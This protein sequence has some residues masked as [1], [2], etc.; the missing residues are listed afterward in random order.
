[1]Q[2]VRK[3]TL[4]LLTLA[5]R[6]GEPAAVLCGAADDAVVGALGEYGASV[7]YVV[8]GTEEFL[9]VPA[10][11]AL[12]EIAGRVQPAAI[13]ITS[14]PTGKDV[15]ARAAVRL[16]SGIITDAVDVQAGDGGLTATQSVFAGTWHV[17]SQVVRGVPVV[18]V[19]PNA[20]SAEP[21]PVTPRVEQVEV[22][23]SDTARGAKI[24]SRS[25]KVSS[26]RP[27]LTDAGVVVSGGRGVG[28][29]EGFE[30][31]ERLADALGAAVGATRAVTDLH[32]V[33]HDLQVGQTGK[34]VAPS[35]Y[36][37]AGI[38]GAI[39]HRAG[40]QSSKTIVAVNKDPKAPIFGVS[41]FGVVGDLHKVVPA[42]IDEIAKRK[43]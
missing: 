18:T 23:F 43:H 1:P 5:R 32:W 24:T 34:T 13:L 14:G 33:A 28:T 9:S 38:S 36:V 10:A 25:P 37:A 22:G 8:P 19:R 11:E 39:Q 12:V 27:E 7:V 4:E 21:A 26:G 6:L 35:L 41:D 20:I 3:A 16:D 17:S 31:I 15:A 42:L 29:Q 2:G 40:M 30:V